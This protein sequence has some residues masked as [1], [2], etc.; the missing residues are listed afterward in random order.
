[1][2]SLLQ[3]LC[4]SLRRKSLV[5]GSLLGSRLSCQGDLVSLGCPALPLC[6]GHRTLGMDDTLL[7]KLQP[8]TKSQSCRTAFYRQ[9]PANSQQ[10][11]LHPL[12]FTLQA[13][14]PVSLS[15]SAIPLHLQAQ[16]YRNS[17]TDGHSRADQSFPYREGNKKGQ[18]TASAFQEASLGPC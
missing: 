1:M 18:S 8:S 3:G 13:P 6:S 14:V 4:K 15:G 5:P 16:R 17:L 9:V 2:F 12:L 7:V 11:G 10:F